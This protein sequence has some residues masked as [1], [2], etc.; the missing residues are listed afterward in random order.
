MHGNTTCMIST[1]T[2][3]Q[4]HLYALKVLPVTCEKALAAAQVMDPVGWTAMKLEWGALW[5][6][7]HDDK[8]LSWLHLVSGQQRPL[9]GDTWN[10]SFCARA[11]TSELQVLHVRQGIALRSCTA[12]H[13]QHQRCSAPAQ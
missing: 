7:A 2:L 13:G 4:L 6:V 10:A 12:D 3:Q 5:W 1:A 11:M 8:V 9:D